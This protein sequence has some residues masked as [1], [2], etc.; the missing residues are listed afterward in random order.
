MGTSGGSANAQ[1]ATLPNA[2]AIPVGVPLEFK[3]G[4][5]NTGPATLNINSIGNVAVLRW[6]P[7]GFVALSGGELQSGQLTTI[8]YDG[9]NL[10]IK[11]P[12][13]P[14]II[15]STIE[16]RGPSTPTGYLIEDGS[17][18][19]RT[20]YAPLFAIIG[21]TFGACDGSTTFGVP[22]SRGSAFAAFDNQGSNG[23]ANRI[24]TFCG[25]AT[26][27][28]LCGTQ[29]TTLGQTNIPNYTMTANIVDPG[30]THGV[31]FPS[32]DSIQA[33]NLSAGGN[34]FYAHFGGVGLAA[35]LTATNSTTGISATVPSGGSGTP[36]SNLPP[37]TTGRRAIKY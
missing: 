27:A 31:N 26:S 20:T 24:G 15:S 19:S 11:Y 23:N 22:D 13:N 36:F 21:S 3:P 10:L 25:A 12:F 4:A 1:T 34:T 18:V 35:Q 37:L 32:P 17:C 30:H 28:G 6:Q 5:T 14:A 29:T 2:T 7:S 9:T 16:F 8:E 33:G